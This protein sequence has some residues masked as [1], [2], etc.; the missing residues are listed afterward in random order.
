M[1]KVRIVP[2]KHNFIACGEG[3]PTAPLH[4]PVAIIDQ[5]SG[6]IYHKTHMQ[7]SG[8]PIYEMEKNDD[9]YEKNHT[10]LIPTGNLIPVNGYDDFLLQPNIEREDVPKRTDRNETNKS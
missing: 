5:V 1:R 3:L 10:D 4:Y 9:I 2:G 8:V 7:F 6:F